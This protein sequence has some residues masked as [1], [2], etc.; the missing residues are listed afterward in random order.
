MDVIAFKPGNVSYAS[1]GHGMNADTFVLSAQAS[2]AAMTAPDRSL[3]E[4]ILGAVTATVA[5]LAASAFV[6]VPLVSACGEQAASSA[7]SG[8]ARGN[9]VMVEVSGR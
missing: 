1:P 9:R 3:G 4:R 6:S 8:R 2:A 5:G 7:R